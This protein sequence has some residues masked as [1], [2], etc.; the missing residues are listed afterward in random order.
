[1]GIWHWLSPSK[2]KSNGL[3][4]SFLLVALL[5]SVSSSMWLV[6]WRAEVTLH[7]L[8][9]TAS[10]QEAELTVANLNQYLDARVKVLQDLARLPMLSNTVMGTGSSAANLADF[11]DGYQLLGISEQLTLVD[12]EGNPIYQNFQRAEQEFPIEGVWFDTLVSGERNQAISLWHINHDAVFQ[13][14]VPV[15]YNGFTEGVLIANLSTGLQSI[16]GSILSD[17]MHSVILNGDY[18]AY[19]TQVQG[20][21]Y[22]V[23]ATLPIGETDIVLQFLVDETLYV[24]EKTGFMQDIG[25]AIVASLLFSFSILIFFGQRLVLNPFKQLERSEKAIRESEERYFLA[26]RGSND[27]IWD[28][29]LINQSIYLSPRIREL[30]GYE[31]KDTS[32]IGNDFGSVWQFVAKPD[33]KR[34]YVAIQNHLEKQQNLDVEIR[35]VAKNGDLLDFRIKGRARLTDNGIAVRMSGSVTDITIQK[36]AQR[37]LKIAKERND[38]LAQAIEASPV[39]ISIADA[40]QQGFPLVYVNSAF[41]RIT[42]YQPEEALGVNCRFL[43][44]EKTQKEKVE[45]LRLALSNGEKLNLELINYKKSG[46]EFWNELYISPVFDDESKL[47]AFVGVQQDTTDRKRFESELE[48]SKLDAEL[49]SKA[50][51]EFLASMSHEIRTPMN[52]VLGMLG[53]L[54]HSQLDNEQKRKLSV[55]TSSARSLLSLINDILDYSKVEAGKLEL[56]LLD[57]D[58]HQLLEE[59]TSAMGFMANDKGLELVLDVSELNENMVKGDP[60]RLRQILTNLVSNAIKFTTKGEVLI[61]VKNQVSDDRYLL[62]VDIKDTGIGI[63]QEKIGILFDSFSQV[64]ASTTR[65]YGGTG[66]GL[67]IVKQLCQLMDGD[68]TVSSKVGSGSTFSVDIELKTTPQLNIE[69]PQVDI[70]KMH[71]LV[72]DDNDTNR[73]VLRGQLQRWGAKVSEAIDGIEALGICERYLTEHDRIFDAAF[74]DMQMPNMD[75]AELGKRLQA[76]E[77][78]KPMKLVMMTSMAKK[79]DGRY[80]AD[81]GFSGYFPKP[82]VSSDLI[83]ALSVMI[84]DGEALKQAEPLV[85]R[86]YLRHLKKAE[87]KDIDDIELNNNAHILLAEDNQINQLV[88]TGVLNAFG[89]DLIDVADNGKEVIEQ[90]KRAPADNP[91]QLILMDCQM[92]EMDGYQ[93][94]G[95]IRQGEAGERYRQIPIIAMTANA[96]AGDREECINAGMDDYISKPIDNQ[97]LLKKLKQWL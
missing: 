85:N 63:P 65:Q 43:Q 91:F 79:G 86:H 87:P 51:S 82:A 59:F 7:N 89:M 34:L 31:G 95:F 17:H 80:F 53:L 69:M 35:A 66:L 81:L 58:I 39:G 36:H 88:A 76:D 18:L 41:T 10:A 75:G 90:L 3:F 57:F 93:A 45:L 11:F 12:I 97:M 60:S 29:D 28:W 16:I 40:T 37:E 49:A 50:K 44:G 2:L 52:G 27:G 23:E 21:N 33:R 72:V 96:M 84:D 70:R 54:S 94:T 47:V 8:Q 55:A 20:Q 83:E 26:V 73:D 61:K 22:F 64:D 19:S 71:I 30:L 78:F 9:Q 24:K 14:A 56:E 32:T 6:S 48:Q 68:V 4:Y 15:F 38:L 77:H 92:P 5:L 13:V 62:H 74:L 46:E 42:G 67:A 1:M 25:M